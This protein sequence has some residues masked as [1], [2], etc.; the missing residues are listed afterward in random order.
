MLEAGF[1]AGQEKL[2][3]VALKSKL[4][5]V[6]IPAYFGQSASERPPDDLFDPHK[7]PPLGADGKSCCPGC[8]IE[9]AAIL[10]ECSS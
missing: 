7:L 1:G 6:T 10:I 4:R 3:P 2:D 9:A 8:H 5:K